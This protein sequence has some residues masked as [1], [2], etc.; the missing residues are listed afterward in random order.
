MFEAPIVASR[1]PGRKPS[2]ANPSVAESNVRSLKD[3]A[4]VIWRLA[5]AHSG[6]PATNPC[7]EGGSFCI[8]R[9][10]DERKPQT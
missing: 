7:T 2:E 5:F 6:V 10:P 9:R 3:A 1:V 8:V 4:E